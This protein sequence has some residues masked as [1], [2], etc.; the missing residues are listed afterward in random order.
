MKIVKP[1][2]EI[3]NKEKING[4]DILKNIESAGRTC[5]K[6]EDKITDESC[7]QFV[8]NVLKR[9]HESVIEHEF[10]SVRII[11]DRGLLA[12]ISRHRIC[13]LSVESSRFCNYGNTKKG[14]SFIKPYFL[15]DCPV[16]EFNEN[17]LCDDETKEKYSDS[18]YDFIF[19]LFNCE[20][21]YNRM[22]ENGYK[23]EDARNIL[24]NA[25]K[26]EIVMTCNLREWRHFFKLRTSPAAHPSMRELTIPM[27]AEFKKL[28]P[29]VF[30]D[31]E[32]KE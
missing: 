17:D 31:I 22:L 28:I 10:L 3:R 14:L 26:T 4:L 25:L 6:S 24:P 18:T 7:L 23:P 13:S 11:C 27:L 20:H 30:D 2:F 5:Y 21:E 12:E 29:I 16:G 19:Y 15:P 32:V 1:S 9:G 8:K